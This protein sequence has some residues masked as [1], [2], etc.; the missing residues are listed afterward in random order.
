MWLSECAITYDGAP[1]YSMS[2]MEFTDSLVTH[3]T[4][5]FADP[6]QAP[7]WRAALGEPISGGPDPSPNR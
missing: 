6:F 5:Y 1:T 3:E 7:S 2:I 4:H